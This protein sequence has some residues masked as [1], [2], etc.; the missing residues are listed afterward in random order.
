ME[1]WLYRSKVTVSCTVCQDKEL[2][3]LLDDQNK[4]TQELKKTAETKDI[5][6]EKPD[7]F[8][9]EKGGNVT[10]VATATI[11][12]KEY[13]V[14]TPVTVEAGQHTYGEPTF[15]WSDDL[16][17]CTATVKCMNCGKEETL[18]CAITSKKVEPTCETA[19]KRHIQQ[20]WK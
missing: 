2:D 5:K 18:D 4:D 8:D 12:G 14:S 9:C 16:E 17:T 7:G 6:V 20:Q 3:A 11:D 1:W 10:Y 19:G 15:K 13:T